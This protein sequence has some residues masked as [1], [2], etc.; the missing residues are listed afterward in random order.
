MLRGLLLIASSK[1]PS[2]TMHLGLKDGTV[3]FTHSKE[4]FPGIFSFF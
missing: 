1:N 3:L 4:T 2:V